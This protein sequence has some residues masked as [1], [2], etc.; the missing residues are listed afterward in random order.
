MLTRKRGSIMNCSPFA[1]VLLLAA[2]T[3]LAQA[4]AASPADSQQPAPPPAIK[5]FDLSAI[6]KTAD[7]CTDF[8]QYACGNWIKNNPIPGDQ[9]RWAR[10][11]SMLQ[12]R[13]RYYLWQ[14]LDAAATAPK[15]PLQKKYGSF[16]AACM[17]TDLIEKKGLEP[18][19]SALD[20]IASLNDPHQLAA[21]VGGLARQGDPAPLFRFGIQQD[22]KDSSKQI[23][24]IGQA[25]L[26]LPD[27]D[28]YLVDNKRFQTIFQQYRD[29]L[30][31]MFT[32]A[33][34]QPGH[35]AKEADAVLKIETALA[36]ASTPRV[37]LRDPEKRY[38]IYTTTDFQK[39][40]PDFDYSVYFKDVKVGHFDTLNVSTPDFFKA[41]NQLLASEPVD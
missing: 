28:Y 37:D 40:T 4:P 38:H 27:R 29:N 13:N 6:D 18:I 19:R 23:A 15:T 14:E 16:F 34:D 39:L 1:A 33:G 21:I 5:S 22:E 10:S 3:A 32:L 41:L 17:N 24:S 8:Y 26:S 30:T 7:P 20:R 25:G 35:A 9:V 12:E 36:Q 31:K 2:G 11:F